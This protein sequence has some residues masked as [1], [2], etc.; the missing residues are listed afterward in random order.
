[1]ADSLCL[2][3]LNVSVRRQ[4]FFILCIFFLPLSAQTAT[5]AL[6]GDCAIS[7]VSPVTTSVIEG[8][9]IV[10]CIVANSVE[11]MHSY[12]VKISFDPNIV[13]FENASA[14]LSPL[15]PAF[16][17]SKGGKCAAFIAIPNDTENGVEIAATQAGKNSSTTVSGNGVLGYCIFTAKMKGDPKINI[18][19]ARLVDPEGI[20]TFAVI[21]S[22]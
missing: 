21:G 11:N 8:E 13:S 18:I 22:L 19:E 17:E 12:S 9:K 14:K 16:I 15:T 1:M 4:I 2:K 6:D 7:G 5:V 10:V 3:T 20:S